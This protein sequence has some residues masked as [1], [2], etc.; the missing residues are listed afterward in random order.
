[1]VGMRNLALLLSLVALAPNALAQASERKGF[2]IGASIGLAN[3]SPDLCV[4]C[5]TGIAVEGRVG[6]MLKPRLALLAD[7]VSTATSPEILST[8]HGRHTGFLGAVQY[9]P[10]RRL[11]LRAGAG[12]ASVEREAPP[13]YDYKTTHFAGI[14]GVG[15]EVNPG[16]KLVVELALLDLLSGDSPQQSPLEPRHKSTVNTVLFSIGATFYSRR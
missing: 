9:W 1:M 10:S 8:V 7:L 13:V 2:L 15:F 4:G 11:W 12:A 5:E 14:G 16:S 3:N 6:W